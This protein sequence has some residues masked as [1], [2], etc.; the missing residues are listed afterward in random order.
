MSNRWL[1]GD[2]GSN[3]AGIEEK[4][5]DQNKGNFGGGDGEAQ[6]LVVS[7]IRPSHKIPIPKGFSCCLESESE[8]DCLGGGEVKWMMAHIARIKHRTVLACLLIAATAVKRNDKHTRSL[9]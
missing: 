5:K 8:Q 9:I 3:R 7:V 2:A 4:G 1:S 6:K